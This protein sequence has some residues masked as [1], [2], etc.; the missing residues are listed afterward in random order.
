[1][2]M[3]ALNALEM[4][5]TG[6]PITGCV[7]MELSGVGSAVAMRGSTAPR[8]RTVNQDDMAS[9]VPQVRNILLS[10]EYTVTAGHH[11]EHKHISSKA[12]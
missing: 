5:A 11:Q 4:L 9:T 8:V 1:M 2:A 6:A 3:S 10:P 12:N 7:R